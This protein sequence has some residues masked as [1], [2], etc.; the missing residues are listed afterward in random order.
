MSRNS[1]T[2]TR[3]KGPNYTDS[4]ANIPP[5]I[6]IDSLNVY[7]DAGGYLSQFQQPTIL[8]TLDDPALSLGALSSP[9]AYPRLLVQQG[10]QLSLSDYPYSALSPFAH[11]LLAGLQARLDHVLCNGIAY[12]NNGQDS[13]YSIPGN[14][15]RYLWGIVPPPAPV[16]I[17]LS[18]TQ[19]GSITIQ[20]SS[21]VVTVDF[22]NPT[23]AVPGQPIYIDSDPSATW[24]ASFDGVFPIHTVLTTTSIT[25]L[26]PSLPDA[27]PFTRATYPSGIT[28]TTG[29]QYGACYG[30][31]LVGHW[32]SLSP[33]SASTGPVT[34]TSPVILVPPSTDWQVDQVALFRNQD[35][36]APGGGTW[37][38]INNGILPVIA[39]G[40][41]AGYAVFCDTTS[42]L[43]LSTSG[44]TAPYDNGVAPAGK[45]LAA[46]LDRVM[47]CGITNDENGVRYTGYETIGFGRP[48]MSWCQYNEIKLGQGQAKPMGMGLLR[49]G[50]M[51]FFADNGFMYI[52]RGTLS[53]ISVSAPTSLSF[54]AEQ[55]PYSIGLY[56]H[57]SIQSSAAGL[58]WLDDGFNLRVM[59]NS[60]F[61]PPKVIA[62][63]LAGL[64]KRITPG[65]QDKVASVHFDY[66]QRD[67]YAISLPID[68]SE[69]NNLTVFVD[70]TADPAKNT[71]SWPVQHSCSGFAWAIY[72][73]QTCHL[74]SLQPQIVSDTATAP[75]YLTEIPVLSPITQGIADQSQLTA[76]NPPMPGAFWRGGYFGLHDEQGEDEF[77][78]MKEFRYTRLGG[79]IA[80]GL[81]IQAYLVNGEEWTWDN[82]TVV[83]FEMDG[84]VGGLNM[85]ARCL[86]PL[87]IF[88]DSILATVT[89]LMLAWNVTSIR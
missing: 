50:G 63:G 58:I 20:R 40:P 49:Y 14:P 45:Y 87:I 36:V 83:E 64:F 86:S 26:Q 3:F 82:P 41:Y 78:M 38:L 44:Q 6:A 57:F 65:S 21:G 77:S 72:P 46:W 11:G 75:G 31:S 85:K 79:S 61:Y 12:F 48:Q 88:P 9:N 43:S 18:T 1:H 19:S 39:I 7:G 55:M 74:L 89:S 76:P 8:A 59:D 67:W 25:Y 16:L 47:M 24:D 29:W 37:L 73:D 56:S 66:L 51:V 35:G 52:Y 42:D 80:D 15:T 54:Y 71:G 17:A 4:V 13:G 69:V 32:S 60:G 33:L 70:V 34:A 28:A 53:D 84:D 22:D 81:R 27:G 2:I 10:N 62:P 30:A 23:S 68:G 5:D